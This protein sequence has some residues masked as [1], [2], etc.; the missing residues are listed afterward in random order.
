M[1]ICFLTQKPHNRLYNNTLTSHQ[2]I[3]PNG[4]FDD[5]PY[6]ESAYAEASKQQ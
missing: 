4:S 3:P 6:L 5:I 2:E 1:F